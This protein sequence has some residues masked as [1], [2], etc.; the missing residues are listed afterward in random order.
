MARAW[1]QALVVPV[2]RDTVNQFALSSNDQ[3]YLSGLQ[4][5][6]HSTEPAIGLVCKGTGL[7]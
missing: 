2:A 5:A 7:L 4:M 1:S 6:S 3:A